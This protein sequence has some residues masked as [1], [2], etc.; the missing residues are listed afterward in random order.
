MTVSDVMTEHVYSVAPESSADEARALMRRRRV[1]HLV[2]KNTRGDWVGLVSAHDLAR[3]PSERHKRP[4][5][6]SDVMT[7][8]VLTIDE[9]TPVNRAA[10]M[11]RGRSIGSL[12]VLRKGEIVGIITTA[13]LLRQV[14]LGA[15]R[16][17]RATTN[18]AVH[19]RVGHRPRSRGD[20]VW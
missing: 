11:M 5:K 9:Q 14:D 3:R 8:H 18:A 12:L 4:L 13:D 15:A 10:F 2:V 1:H 16:R 19:H 6:V 17:S 20:G 7:R